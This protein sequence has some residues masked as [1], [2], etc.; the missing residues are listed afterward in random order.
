MVRGVRNT[1]VR[2]A[3]PIA[4]STHS[5]NA[6]LPCRGSA[7]FASATHSLALLPNREDAIG[8]TGRKT[9]NGFLRRVGVG[10][11]PLPMQSRCPLRRSGFWDHYSPSQ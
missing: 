10:Q 3:G 2:A 1:A 6:E 9:K 8:V 7:D 5:S 4:D 11:Q